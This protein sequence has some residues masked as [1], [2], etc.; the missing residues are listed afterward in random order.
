MPR[1]LVATAPY[2]VE[3]QDYTPT[4]MTPTKVRIE[5]EFASGKHGT[6]QAMF[7]GRNFKGQTFDADMRMFK[8]TPTAATTTTPAATKKGPDV[9]GTTGVGTV[10][11]VGAEVT[12]FKKGDRVIGLM[13]VA[14]HNTVEQTRLWHLGDI[15][16]LEA[17]CIEPAYVA[18]HAVRESNIRIGDTVAVFGLGAI[19]L[20]AVQLARA[21]GASR[22]I[23]IDPLEN[24]RQWA[25]GHGADVVIDPTKEDAP[26]LVHKATGGA[27]VDVAIE[28]AGSYRALEG[29]LKSTRITGTVCA[30]GFY[31]GEAQGVW[32]G[33]EFH[34]NRLQ[35][36]VPHGCGW[37]HHARDYPRWTE[38]RTYET[39][40]GMLQHKQLDFTGLINPLVSLDE[41]P[42]VWRQINEAPGNVIKFGV[43]F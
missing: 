20:T 7:D 41:A 18:F 10:I 37:G 33:R 22:V 23:A 32:L 28:A 21:A 3:V 6:V 17:L 1:R 39:L 16:P 38:E 31:Q 9:I 30:A 29:A 13:S 8:D 35:I 2:V 42:D 26:L 34:H 25:I 14:S 40:V 27:G 5:T 4:Q 24:R 19:G 36:V 12:R 15:D 11:A 43:R